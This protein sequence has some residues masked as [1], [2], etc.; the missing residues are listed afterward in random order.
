MPMQRDVMKAQADT[1][2]A[3][4]DEFRRFAGDGVEGAAEV[5]FQLGRIA[6]LVRAIAD[7]VPAPAEAADESALPP[8]E[9]GALRQG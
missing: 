5:G 9:T 3:W 7:G 6:K 4:G 1:L 8:V 2:A